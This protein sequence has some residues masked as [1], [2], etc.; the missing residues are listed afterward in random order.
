MPSESDIDSLSFLVILS[1]FGFWH[2]FPKF[3]DTSWV[4]LSWP[5]M[6]IR[7][8][9][10]LG[11][12]LG[13]CQIFWRVEFTEALL[14]NSLVFWLPSLPSPRME[15]NVRYGS[16]LWSSILMNLTPSCF[17]SISNIASHEIPSHSIY[18]EFCITVF[19]YSHISVEQMLI[20]GKELHNIPPV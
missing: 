4:N 15:T 9:S 8:S 12:S 7:N 1:N 20:F 18:L 5:L 16:R 10:R 6:V 14:E 19:T 17:S 3:V 13:Q 11:R 2:P